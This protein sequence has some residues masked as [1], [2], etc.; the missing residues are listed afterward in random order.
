VLAGVQSALAAL[1]GQFMAGLGGR[2]VL[3][4]ALDS[5]RADRPCVYTWMAL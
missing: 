2:F 5:L 4:L 1:P 3:N